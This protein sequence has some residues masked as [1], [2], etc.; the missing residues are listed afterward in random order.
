[1]INIS[2]YLLNKWKLIYDIVE[3]LIKIN[4]FFYLVINK[5]KKIYLFILLK[6]NN[7]ILY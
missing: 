2:I 7:I 6:Y 5:L 3:D 1:M 4:I